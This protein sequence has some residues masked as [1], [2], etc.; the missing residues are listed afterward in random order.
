MDNDT[1]N[2]M[3]DDLDIMND[4]SNSIQALMK[5]KPTSTPLSTSG[6]PRATATD[7]GSSESAKKP[8][9]LDQAILRSI[10][11]CPTEDLK[12]KMYTTILIVGGGLKFNMAD[13][14][15]LKKLALQ[16]KSTLNLLDIY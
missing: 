9:P 7:E 13:K 3:E 16:V 4:D 12:K 8:L 5:S 14:F 2:I 6:R 1:S 10:E 11:A 15:L